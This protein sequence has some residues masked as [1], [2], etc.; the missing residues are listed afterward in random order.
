MPVTIYN[1]IDKVAG[2]PQESVHVLIEL[3]WDTNESPVARVDEEETMIQGSVSLSSDADGRWEKD[4]VPN[5][6]ILPVD[7]VYRITETLKSGP[8]STYFISLS[9]GATAD[10][11]V[12]DFLVAKPSWVD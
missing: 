5:D 4:V 7:N 11:W 1:N 6:V 9:D 8:V 2:N 3:L 12:G 10:F